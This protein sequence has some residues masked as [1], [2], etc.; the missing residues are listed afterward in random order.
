MQ[1]FLA[2]SPFR[3]DL[4]DEVI[5][6]FLLAETRWIFF[7]GCFEVHHHLEDDFCSP[8]LRP[9]HRLHHLRLLQL[10]SSFPL[11]PTP[12]ELGVILRSACNRLPSMLLLLS[13]RGCGNP[14]ESKSYSRSARSHN[15]RRSQRRLGVPQYGKPLKNPIGHLRR[16]WSGIV[17]SVV[18]LVVLLLFL[19]LLV[20]V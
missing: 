15:W 6:F 7:A 2:A 4:L 17:A 10:F 19:L 3:I 1:S 20:V 14:R 5:R 11:T 12:R 9:N 8:E 18:L 13:P 16:G